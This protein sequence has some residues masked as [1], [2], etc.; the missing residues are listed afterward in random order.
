M[1]KS[2]NSLHNYKGQYIKYKGQLTMGDEVSCCPGG[3]PDFKVIELKGRIGVICYTGRITNPTKYK[4]YF[5][6]DRGWE[7]DS[8]SSG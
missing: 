5:N 4:I 6:K 8:Q 1:S 3:T 7:W 2:L